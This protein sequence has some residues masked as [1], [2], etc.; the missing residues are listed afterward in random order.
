PSL[1]ENADLL[2]MTDNIVIVDHHRKM[3]GHIEN[4]VLSYHEP[5]ASSCSELVAELL[6][7]METAENK[8]TKLEAEG[9]LAGIMLDSRDFSVRTGVRTFEAAS[10][11]RRLGA[12]PTEAKLFFSTDLATYKNK[13]ELVASAQLYRGCAVI[14]SDKLPESMRVVIPQA[15]D[16]LLNIDGI[17]ASI[18]AV[19]F[20][21]KVHI[22]SRSLGAYNVQLIM[23]HLGGGGHQTMAGVQLDDADLEVVKHLI[24]EA[25]DNY[26]DKNPPMK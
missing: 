7:H 20:Q 2:T 17:S 24:Y 9:M 10:Y 21:N 5:Y 12:A 15:A 8:P 26:L 22:S 18:V 1:V 16:D 14:V 23:E 3:V 11:L 25:I 4:A 19:K 13:S 6:Q